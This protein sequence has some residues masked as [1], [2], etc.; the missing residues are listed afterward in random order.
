MAR[1]ILRSPAEESDR[2]ATIGKSETQP[3]Q[4]RQTDCSPLKGSSVGAE[5]QARRVDKRPTLRRKL[6]GRKAEGNR[7]RLLS[8]SSS[9]LRSGPMRLR[10]GS[11]R[12]SSAALSAVAS[13]RGDGG[14]RRKP[15]EDLDRS[16]G[17]DVTLRPRREFCKGPDSAT[18]QPDYCKALQ[19]SK[20]SIRFITIRKAAM[21]TLTAPVAFG[22]SGGSLA[23]SW[24]HFRRFMTCVATGRNLQAWV[25]SRKAAV[26]IQISS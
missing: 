24:V 17:R 16:K 23:R 11:S 12:P 3:R 15:N 25:A 4:A 7:S 22:Q 5:H 13:G 20:R 9:R 26:A 8:A 6:F 2:S 10:P 19:P 21:P 1:S 14:E 18:R